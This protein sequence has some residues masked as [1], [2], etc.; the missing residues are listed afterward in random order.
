M[1]FIIHAFKKLIPLFDSLL[2]VLKNI[3]TNA[4]L[5]GTVYF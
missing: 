5:S 2:S 1:Y 3:K 4:I